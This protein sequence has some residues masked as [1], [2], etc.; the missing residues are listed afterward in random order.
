MLTNEE[1]ILPEKLVVYL[2]IIYIAS[3]I[4]K[5]LLIQWN[6]SYLSTWATKS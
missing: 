3:L 6:W 2:D 4:G 1:K 5:L